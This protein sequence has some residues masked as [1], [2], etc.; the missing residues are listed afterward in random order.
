MQKTADNKRKNAAAADDGDLVSNTKTGN[1]Q[2]NF[3]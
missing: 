1:Q 3:R 2:P